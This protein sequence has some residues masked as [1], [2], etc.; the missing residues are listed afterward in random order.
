MQPFLCNGP[1]ATNGVEDCSAFRNSFTLTLASNLQLDGGNRNG[2][3]KLLDFSFL[4]DVAGNIAP[5]IKNLTPP[6]N[7]RIDWN[8]DNQAPQVIIK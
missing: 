4:T 1:N 2:H 8:V 6:N 7:R 5:V 3:W